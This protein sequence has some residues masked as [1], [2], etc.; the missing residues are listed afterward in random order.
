MLESSL[1]AAVQ[2]QTQPILLP[3]TN[4]TQAARE[5]GIPARTIR[6]WCSAYGPPLARRAGRDWMVDADLLRELAEQRREAP[7]PQAPSEPSREE[8]IRPF[9][10][11]MPHEAADILGIP[12]KTIRRW[13]VGIPGLGLKLKGDRGEW[14][15]EP[16]VLGIVFFLW[17]DEKT[18]LLPHRALVRRSP[19]QRWLLH[20]RLLKP[21]SRHNDGETVLPT[22]YLAAVEAHIGQRLRPPPP[23]DAAAVVQPSAGEAGD[24]NR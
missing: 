9:Y 15:I 16:G 5:T 19:Q 22:W 3:E 14:M 8:R 7:S 24:A 23:D 12:A 21:L 2:T 4:V 6:T 20:H 13:C 17:R 10:R 11:L 1:T 18:G